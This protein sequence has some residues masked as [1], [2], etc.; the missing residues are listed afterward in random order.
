MSGKTKK[1]RT[2]KQTQQVEFFQRKDKAGRRGPD[3]NLCRSSKRRTQHVTM[4]PVT[5]SI[6]GTDLMR[7]I[8]VSGNGCVSGDW[9]LPITDYDI[10]NEA[11]EDAI[12][13]GCTDFLIGAGDVFNMD[14][15]SDYLPKQDDAG[16]APEIIAANHLF[17]QLLRVFDKIIISKGNH[18]IRFIRQLGWKLRFE[19]SL[20]MIL[21][22]LTPEELA[23]IE[24]TARDYVLVDSPE[25]VWRCTHTAEYS[26]SPL[27]IP[28]RLADIYQQHVIGFHRH[29]HAAGFSAAGY[30]VIEG[31]GWFD[32]G[33]TEYLQQWTKSFP[34]W[35]HGTTF[36]R[37]GRAILP[38]LA[39]A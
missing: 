4:P 12:R 34:K 39:V 16:L 30:R 38:R 24:F 10:V 22:D 36:L 37:E 1:C 21:F 19:H 26:R 23:R 5:S 20:R 35:Q 33:K 18:D 32:R 3:C 13:L 17:K 2:C 8:T 15:L 7:E 14:A 31:G 29:H 11:C 9:H 25:G 27:A 28:G 6:L